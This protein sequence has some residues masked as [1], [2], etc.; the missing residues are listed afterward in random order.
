MFMNPF[1]EDALKSML[2]I[3]FDIFSQL[4]TFNSSGEHYSVDAK[5]KSCGKMLNPYYL[6]EVEEILTLSM[7]GQFLHKSFGNWK[8]ACIRY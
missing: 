1:A 6:V 2:F 8:I 4:S 5:C 3:N 7:S